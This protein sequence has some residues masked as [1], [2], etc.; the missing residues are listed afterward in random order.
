MSLAHYYARGKAGLMNI[1]THE[2]VQHGE[3]LL[4]AGGTGLALGLISASIGGLDK[5][6]AGMEVP[7]DGAVSFGLALAGLS[8]KSPELK[9]ASIAA[10]GSASTRTFEKFFKKTLA[11]GDFDGNDIPFGHELPAMGYG[12]G[13]EQDSLMATAE[14]L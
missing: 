4:I 1:N 10:A 5:H 11:H 12:Y 3:D 2:A 7:V 9:V 8:I 14:Y 6:V 13:A